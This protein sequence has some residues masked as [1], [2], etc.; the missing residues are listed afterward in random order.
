LLNAVKKLKNSDIK[1]L[2]AG[3]GR[4][5]IEVK[6]YALA[7]GLGKQCFFLGVRNDI[8]SLMKSVDLNVL[9]TEYE[10]LSGV[11]IESLVANK[12]FIGTDVPGVKEIVGDDFG[13]VKFQDVENLAKKIN[14]LLFDVEKIRQNTNLNSIKVKKF[15]IDTMLKEHL[16]LYSIIAI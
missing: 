4:T 15:D 12:P 3:E 1:L 13:L 9:S 2:F 10:G 11:T 7:N 14:S 6:R 8:R 5:Q 16:L